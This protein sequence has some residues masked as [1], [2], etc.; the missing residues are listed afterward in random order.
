M[1]VIHNV[2]VACP[3]IRKGGGGAKIGKAYCYFIFFNF[4]R[5]SSEMTSIFFAF[6]F[7][8]GR[9]QAPWATPGHA[10]VYIAPNITT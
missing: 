4:S 6:Q 9:G 2:P 3:G 5:P 10:P 7:L 8:G 1:Y